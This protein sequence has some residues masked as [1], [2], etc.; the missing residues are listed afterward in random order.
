LVDFSFFLS[1]AQMVFY[2]N[3]VVALQSFPSK[4][5]QKQRNSAVENTQWLPWCSCLVKL[6]SQLNTVFFFCSGEELE[7]AWERSEMAWGVGGF[8]WDWMGVWIDRLE[9]ST[10]SRHVRYSWEKE[11]GFSIWN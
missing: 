11:T 6:Y 9:D 3:F 5:K 7:L 4:V 1:L 2:S 10:T 8:G